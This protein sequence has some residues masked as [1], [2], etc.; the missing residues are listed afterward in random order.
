MINTRYKQCIIY[1]MFVTFAFICLAISIKVSDDHNFVGV[2]NY[3]YVLYIMTLII[4]FFCELKQD[5]YTYSVLLC[6][7]IYCPFSIVFFLILNDARIILVIAC[8]IVTAICNIWLFTF[9]IKNSD[10]FD[11]YTTIPESAFV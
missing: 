2:K 3:T 1:V 11:T 5:C 4:S 6:Y 10:D 7:L 9:S 8:S